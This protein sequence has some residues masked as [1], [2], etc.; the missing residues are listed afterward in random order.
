[1][2]DYTA[3]NIDDIEGIAFGSFKRARSAVGASAFG[4][5]VL[6]LP[7]NADGY[8]E[9]DHSDGGQEEVY[10][11]LGGGGDIEIDGERV[12]LSQDTIIRV[13]PSARRKIWPGAEGARVLAIGGVPGKAYEVRHFTE[14]GA[15]DP[16]AK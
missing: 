13:G 2:S 15:P 5:Q 11:T 4:M 7:P 8:P 14:V 12:P 1:M 16:F 6:D 10:V 3:V 9:H